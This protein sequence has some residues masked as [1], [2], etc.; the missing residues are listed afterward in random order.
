MLIYMLVLRGDQFQELWRR[1]LARVLPSAQ[2]IPLSALAVLGDL[3]IGK[4]GWFCVYKRARSPQEMAIQRTLAIIK[5]DVVALRKQGIVLQRI[6]DEGFVVLGMR[7][8]SLSRKEAEGFYAVHRERPFFDSLVDFMISGPVVVL[9]LEREDAVFHWREVLGKTNPADAAE[10]T[11]RQQF[12]ASVGANA[13]H[14][15]DS[16]ENGRIECA[17]FFP[18]TALLP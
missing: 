15:S 5:P 2:P 16:E 10:G 3:V 11:I 18:G 13:A 6:L 12:G 4:T 8:T 14:G 1:Q 9:A 7:Q 17:F